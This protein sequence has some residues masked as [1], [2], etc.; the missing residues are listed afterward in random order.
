MH[1]KKRKSE[2]QPENYEKMPR[3]MNVMEEKEVIHLLPL[4]N[5]TGLI[6]QSMEKPGEESTHKAV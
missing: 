5:K 2:Q 1:A 6:P 4:K 3:K